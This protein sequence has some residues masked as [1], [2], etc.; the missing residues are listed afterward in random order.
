MSAFRLFQA[1]KVWEAQ[2]SAH[3]RRWA[4]IIAV[5]ASRRIC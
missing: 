4:P 1:L 5:P 2:A 3:F